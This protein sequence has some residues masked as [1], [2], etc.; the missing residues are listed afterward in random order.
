MARA[1]RYSVAASL[2]GFITDADGG[3]DWIV[4]DPDIDFGALFAPYDTLVMGRGTYEEA[5][6]LGGGFMG[7]TA[8]VCST[9]LDPDQCPGVTVVRDAAATVRALKQEEGK[10]IWLFGGG[11]LFRN[12]L[13][14]GL[15]DGV[16]VALVP[17]VLGDGLPL[18]PPGP[19][20]AVLRLTDQQTYAA[21][22]IVFLR[23]DVVSPA[24][25]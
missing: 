24:P 4:D 18:I 5:L 11:V 13:E 9:T 15:V 21:S 1:L 14:E 20:R 17:V 25:S 12:L 19:T 10:D 3:V 7:M 6:R 8:Y 16:E 22:G 23:Y 2:D